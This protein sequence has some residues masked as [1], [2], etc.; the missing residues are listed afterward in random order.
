MECIIQSDVKLIKFAIVQLVCNKTKL[1]IDEI[2]L[3]I[4]TWSC[5]WLTLYN[6]ACSWANWI[7][8]TVCFSSIKIIIM[9]WIYLYYRCISDT[10]YHDAVLWLNIKITGYYDMILCHNITV[11]YIIVLYYVAI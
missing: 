2:C 7:N 1:N 5:C 10:K 11:Y 9:R 3:Y 8:S 4:Y 6:L